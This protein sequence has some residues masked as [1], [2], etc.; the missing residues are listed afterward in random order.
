[1]PTESIA[2]WKACKLGIGLEMQ[3]QDWT[4]QPLRNGKRKVPRLFLPS[5][6]LTAPSV[7]Q[8]IGRDEPS[9]RSTAS[10]AFWCSGGGWRDGPWAAIDQVPGF[11]LFRRCSRP[12]ASAPL[13]HSFAQRLFN[14]TVVIPKACA[15]AIGSLFSTA[16]ATLSSPTY[17]RYL[18]PT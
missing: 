9:P 1:M 6:A 7:G 12:C 16:P 10:G 3:R 2:R 13:H 14:S 5:S 11:A 15:V 17:L 8:Q 4:A 18:I